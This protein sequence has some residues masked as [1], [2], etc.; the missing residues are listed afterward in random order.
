MSFP[1]FPAYFAGS[2]LI[3][4]VVLV[5]WRSML[6]PEKSL[7]NSALSIALTPIRALGIG[8][9]K[10]KGYYSLLFLLLNV[11]HLQ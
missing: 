6:H 2:A 10:H 8:P 7:L 5:V 11:E 9:Y 3:L 4:Y 1:L